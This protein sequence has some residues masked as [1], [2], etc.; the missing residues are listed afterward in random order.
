MLHTLG[1]LGNICSDGLDRQNKV[2]AHY[3]LSQ[4]LTKAVWRSR[5]VKRWTLC[6]GSGQSA[7]KKV[8]PHH[9]TKKNGHAVI[10]KK[11]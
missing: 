11:R 7:V 9:T 10:L 1:I 4:H 5:V 2:L 8:P 3:P 6:P